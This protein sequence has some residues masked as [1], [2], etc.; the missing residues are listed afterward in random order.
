[1]HKLTSRDHSLDVLSLVNVYLQAAQPGLPLLREG[2]QVQT[3]HRRI[4]LIYVFPLALSGCHD[5]DLSV[6]EWS[7][8]P[9]F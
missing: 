4:K 3:Y 8:I 9:D 7:S 5:I 1:M 6:F 2:M